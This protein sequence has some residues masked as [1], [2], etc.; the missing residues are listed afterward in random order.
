M[1]TEVSV[2]PILTSSGSVIGRS[3]SGDCARSTLHGALFRLEFFSTR[4]V[5]FPV[6][7]INTGNAVTMTL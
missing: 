4:L 3:D 1:P 2:L 7:S 6:Q 5:G